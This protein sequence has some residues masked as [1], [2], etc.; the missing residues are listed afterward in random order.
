M[1]QATLRDGTAQHRSVF[2]L[3]TRRLS[4]GRRYGV[5]AGVGR[6]LDALDD[7]RFGEDEISWLREAEVVDDDTIDWLASYRFNGTIWGYPEGEIYFPSS[8]VLIVEGT[9]AECV[10]LETLFLSILN[11]DSAT[12]S[13]AS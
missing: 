13:A 11:H 3:F 4:G 8:P 12:A 7:F 9:F 2:E 6:L 1:L 10:I 5:V